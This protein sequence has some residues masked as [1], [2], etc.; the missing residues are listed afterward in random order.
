VRW[1]GLG[2]GVRTREREGSGR[3]GAVWGRWGGNGGGLQIEFESGSRARL[4]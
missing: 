2:R 1:D 3:R 4:V